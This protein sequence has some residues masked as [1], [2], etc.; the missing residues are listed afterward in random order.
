ME[1]RTR[2]TARTDLSII[3]PV[4]RRNIAFN[5]E[6]PEKRTFARPLAELTPLGE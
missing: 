2:A 4:P 5:A 6:H 1:H 3:P